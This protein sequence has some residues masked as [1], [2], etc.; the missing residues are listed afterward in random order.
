[1]PGSGVMVQHSEVDGAVPADETALGPGDGVD[2]AGVPSGPFAQPAIE[3]A[4]GAATAAV[5]IALVN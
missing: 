4:I 1:M 3:A 2:A 5:T